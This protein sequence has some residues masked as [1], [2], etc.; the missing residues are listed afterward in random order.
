MNTKNCVFARRQRAL[1]LVL[2]SVWGMFL[3]IPVATAQTS[4]SGTVLGTISDPTGAVVPKAEVQLVNVE[5]NATA[6]QIT[7]DA[8]GYAFPNVVPGTYK[9]TVK[10]TGFRTAVVGNV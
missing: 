4:T 1:A 3:S 5:T 9:I 2:S 6:T 7:N 10:M 8:G